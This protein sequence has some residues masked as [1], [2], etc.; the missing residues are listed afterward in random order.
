MLPERRHD[1]SRLEGFSDAVFAFVLTLLVVSLEVPRSYAKLI[2]LVRGFPSFACCFALLVWIW[3]E[4]NM[5]F[6]RYGLQD[7]YTVFLNAVLLFVVM[8]WHAYRKRVELALTPLEVFD[9][10]AY[11]GHHL[12]SVAVGAVAVIVAFAVPP[13]IAFLSPMCFGLMGPAHWAWGAREG[14]RRRTLEMRLR[15]EPAPSA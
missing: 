5:Y 7:G 10:R 3:H 9:V 8:F 2:E 12:V 14:R 1:I 11:V 6:R 15:G 13:W 4:H